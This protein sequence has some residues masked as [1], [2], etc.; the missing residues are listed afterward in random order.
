MNKHE[1]Q[2]IQKY[3][4]IASD[5]D[6][7]FDGKFTAKFK[8]KILDTVLL[9][10]GDRVLDVGCGNG[11]LIYALKQ[12]ADIHAYGIDISPQ[13]IAE[14]RK[15]Y[16]GID[17][18]VSNGE[19][20]PFEDNYFDTVIICCVLHHLNNPQSFFTQ[21]HRIL[22]PNG[23]LIIGEPKFFLLKPFID[24]IISPLLKAGDNKLFTHKKLKRLATENGFIIKD[25]Y[26]KKFMQLLSVS[27]TA[28]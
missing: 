1:L 7:S 9:N 24:Y 27:K 10:D 2:S 23:T 14:C 22:K 4:R 6:N 5:Y 20:I 28:Y 12:K 11:S 15:R 3:N 26:K 13:M 8:Q 17:F 16:D 21:A 18:K 25:I 19:Q